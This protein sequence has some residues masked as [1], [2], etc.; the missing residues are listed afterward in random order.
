MQLYST[1]QKSEDGWCNYNYYSI[2]SM[3]AGVVVVGV[4]ASAVNRERKSISEYFKE[5]RE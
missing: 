1:Q 3:V 5:H 2:G 4:V